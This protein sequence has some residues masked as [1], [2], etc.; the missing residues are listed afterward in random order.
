VYTAFPD[1]D[2]PGERAV[3]QPYLLQRANLDP[4]GDRDPDLRP[5]ELRAKVIVEKPVP[6]PEPEPVT[7]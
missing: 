3:P 7:P 5:E 6:V 1:P 4:E 2:S